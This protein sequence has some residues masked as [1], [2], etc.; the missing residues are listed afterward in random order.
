[1]GSTRK[2]NFSLGETVKKTKVTP[3]IP[4]KA[5]PTNIASNPD[6]VCPMSASNADDVILTSSSQ[7][8]EIHSNYCI[9]SKKDP[10]EGKITADGWPFWMVLP[11]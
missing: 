5:T 9:L 6:D 7:P 8:K 3:P 10:P 4:I 1:M 2:V 11:T